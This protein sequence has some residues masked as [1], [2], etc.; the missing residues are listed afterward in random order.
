MTI[1]LEG[2]HKKVKKRRCVPLITPRLPE[3]YVPARFPEIPEISIEG[4]FI[5]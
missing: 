4:M 3:K 1:G 5:K 2:K